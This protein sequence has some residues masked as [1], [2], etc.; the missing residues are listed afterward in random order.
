MRTLEDF[1][2]MTEGSSVFIYRIDEE[3][4]GEYRAEL[5]T[6]QYIVILNDLQEKQ[7]QDIKRWLTSKN[8]VE[9]EGY[10]ELCE[11]LRK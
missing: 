4:D 8:A 3:G 10:V 7:I 11:V 2:K 6:S 5:L 1:K 9:T